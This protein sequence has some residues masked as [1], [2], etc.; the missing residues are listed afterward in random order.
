[1]S[2]IIS[3][4]N[5]VFEALEAG[6]PINK[7]YLAAGPRHSIDAKIISL[8][9]QRGIP[10]REVG[11]KKLVELAGHE[12]TQGIMAVLIPM[13][14]RAIEDIF[15]RAREKNEAALIAILDEI[16]DPHNLGAIIRSAEAFGFHG[17]IIPKD[18]SVG[19][20]DTVAKTSAGAVSHI[21]VVRVNNLARALD[22][23]KKD[24]LWIAGAD[25][26]SVTPFYQADL[27]RALGVVIGN[28]GKGLRRLVK[29]KCDFLIRIPM[30]GQISSLNASVAAA[31]IF[32]E[33][34]KQRSS[35]MIERK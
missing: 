12:N 8:A 32:C 13:A 26:D 16:Q 27:N 20:T 22:D 35:S 3:G 29:E 2:T 31:L 19:L 23:L 24:D 10:I 7:I 34:R 14:Y 17:I 30:V 18:R 33:A 4:K 11:R 9:R 1:M 28:E 25:Q 21:P 15:T 5:P 6:L